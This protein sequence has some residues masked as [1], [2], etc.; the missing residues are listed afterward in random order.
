M[1]KVFFNDHQL[2]WNPKI[3]N[4]LKDNIDQFVEIEDVETLFLMLSKL[5]KTE[6]VVKLFLSSKKGD[7]L[8]FLR[9]QLRPIDA[10]GGIVRN[11]NGE[12][13]FIKRF[14]KWD[15]PKGKIEQGET[16]DLA[17]VREVE[18][19]CGIHTL[20]VIKKLPSTFHIYRSPYIKEVNNW[21]LKETHWFEMSYAGNEKLAPQTEEQIE[22]VC[23]LKPS[24][25][26]M[27]YKNTFGNL[28]EL[29]DCYMG[30]APKISS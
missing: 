17:A 25:F 9:E 15:L 29:L 5:E 14:G 2:L 7:L 10:A 19:E 24:Q 26:E 8:S 6:C 16:P 13:L 12:L 3:K 1:Y 23:W 22:E 28:R 11:A 21:V 18:E 27:V 20:Q 4:S 30:Q